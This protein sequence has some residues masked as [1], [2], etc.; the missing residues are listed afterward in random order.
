ML[1]QDYFITKLFGLKDVLFTLIEETEISILISIET[2]P[3]PQICP[4]CKQPTSYI[5]DYRQ[6]KIKDLPF[7]DKYCYLLLKK[8]RYTC[9]RCGKRFYEKYSFLPRYHHMTQ[10]VYVEILR[11]LRNN[12]SMKLVARIPLSTLFRGSLTL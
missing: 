4:C 2:K 11:M 12:C 6:Q 8:R 3:K 9:K 1:S 7:R 10:R 5:H